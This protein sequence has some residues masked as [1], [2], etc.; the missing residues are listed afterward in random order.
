MST[1]KLSKFLVYAPDNTKEGTHEL[2][3]QVR[4][5]HLAAVQPVIKS[6]VMKVGGMMVD[7]LS[8]PEAPQ[9]QAKG[10]LIIYEAE[11]M[12]Q[13]RAMVESDIYYTSGVWDREKLVICPFLPAT[14][15]P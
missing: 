12:E 5:R 3:C 13:V 6:G 7:P 1:G 14:P 9:K 8:D 15:F 10:S 11:S 4:E 2:R